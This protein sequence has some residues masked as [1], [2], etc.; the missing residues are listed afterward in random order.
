PRGASREVTSTAGAFR[1]VAQAVTG[2][3]LLDQGT[4]V[5]E[6]SLLV[7]WEHRLKVYRIDT[8]P[9][10]TKVTDDT[11]AA[12]A[13]EGGSAGLLPA[14]ATSDMKVR[15]SGV[16]RKS[17]RLT[18]L[19]GEFRV[20]AAEKLV[21]FAF[22]SPGGKLPDVQKVAGVSA[23]MKQL[24]KKTDTWEAVVEVTYPPGQP[25]F[26]SFQ[27][28]WWLR[29]NRLSIRSPEGK[30]VALDDYEIPAPAES[31]PLVVIHR[32]KENAAAGIGNPTAKGWSLVYE[33]PAPLVEV[34]VPFELKD[35]PLP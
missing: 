7:H 25:T 27:G 26:E 30:T 16:P 14:N 5:H 23:R 10:V 20:T 24:Q 3:A 19:A 4:T 13:A 31:S 35:I 34:T 9:K 8:A 18:T 33:T 22:E 32:F 17:A 2:R 6:V 28:E 21:T 11:G 1:V 15:L 12:I 29:D